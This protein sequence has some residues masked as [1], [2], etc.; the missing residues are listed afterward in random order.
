MLPALSLS[1]Y[2]TALATS[3]TPASLRSALRRITRSRCSPASPWVISVSRKPGATALTV[4]PS[5]PT[6]RQ[7]SGK[8]QHRSLGRAIDRK[9]AIAGEADDRG[10]I[11]DAAF[12]FR[13]HRAH[14]IF[15]EYDRRQRVDPDKLFDLRIVHQRQRTIEAE[16]GIVDQA[17]QRAEFLAQIAHQVRDV[18]DFAEDERHKAQRAV[19]G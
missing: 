13:H 14:H 19:L 9:P 1:R 8:A 18:F 4:M 16:R 2:S 5:R 7:G 10:H 12:A 15:G 17:E 6:S 11:D 3:S